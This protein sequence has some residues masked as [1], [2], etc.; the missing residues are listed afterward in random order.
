MTLYELGED[1]LRQNDILVEK[2]HRLTDE[3]KTKSG[4]DYIAL[5]ADILTLY[6]MSRELRQT[7][8][9]LMHYYDHCDRK[10]YRVHP[11]LN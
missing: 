6:Q 1:Y 2:I 11:H 4:N 5:K 3:L 9:V 7:A 8:A 10:K